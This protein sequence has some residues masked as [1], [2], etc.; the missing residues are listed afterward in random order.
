MPRRLSSTYTKFFEPSSIYK[1]PIL[2][3]FIIYLMKD[4]IKSVAEKI[5]YNTLNFIKYNYKKNPV[6]IVQKAIHKAKPSIGVVSVR[7]RGQALQVPQ[8]LSPKLKINF[9]IKWII[10][11]AYERKD[12]Y[13]LD[14]KLAL[15]LINASK[16]KGKVIKLRKDLHDLALKSRALIPFKS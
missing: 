4:G 7:K 6:I 5:L 13:T 3:K 14:K 11:Q 10:T 2:A 8:P 12:N 9:A 1:K 16:N 15:E